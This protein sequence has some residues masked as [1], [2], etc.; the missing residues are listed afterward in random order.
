MT[1]T[2]S[3][4]VKDFQK[5]EFAAIYLFYGEEPY[6]IDEL[7]NYLIEH[8]L[9]DEEK[10]FNQ[11]IIYGRE[12]T[13]GQAV[14]FCRQFPMVGGK[15]LVVV[16]EAQDMDIRK[17]ENYAPLL[18]Y[19][20]KPMPTTIMVIDYKYKSPPAKLLKALQKSDKVM[21]FDSKKK[22]DSDLSEWISNQV[23]RV[24]FTISSKACQMLVEFLGNDL[25]KI[26]NE[27]RKLYINHPKE[28]PITDEVIEK[29]I[30]ISK[31]YNVFE[32]QKALAAKD[33]PKANRI[34]W[35]LT[36]NQKENPIFKTIP[37]LFQFFS[38]VLLIHSLTDKS[39]AAV[40]SK[41]RVSYYG[42]DEYLQAYRIY[43]VR[44]LIEIISWLREMNTRALGIE[45]YSCDEGELLK[46][47]IF[48]VLH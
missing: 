34:T 8:V 39:E 3:Q 12:S 38:K 10:E 2:L 24:G 23:Q 20:E 14:N 48:K 27:L 45:N 22:K 16:R 44:K 21:A 37:I 7:S 28:K 4:V 30:G 35:H 36:Q 31:D 9:T 32:L 33:I 1:P 19:I 13:F 40:M 15:Q 43:P 46:E 17:E 26:M 29:F 18:S 5:R 11:L 41:L 25:E 6:Y 42:K 47:F